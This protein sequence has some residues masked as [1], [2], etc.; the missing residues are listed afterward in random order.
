LILGEKFLEYIKAFRPTLRP[1]LKSIPG[2]FCQVEIKKTERVK[3]CSAE[4]SSSLGDFDLI[5]TLRIT[6]VRSD[7]K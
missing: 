2:V 5:M 3:D 1:T 4:G 6:E 7:W